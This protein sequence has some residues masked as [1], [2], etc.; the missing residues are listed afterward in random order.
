MQDVARA[1]IQFLDKHDQEDPSHSHQAMVLAQTVED[2]NSAECFKQAYNTLGLDKCETFVA[3]TNVEILNRFDQGKI[4]TLVIV[5]RLL[6]GYD[7]NHVSVVGIVR[8]VAPSSKVLFSQFVGRAVR[9]AYPADPVTAM[10][11]SHQCFNQ[12]I[13]FDNFDTVTDFDNVDED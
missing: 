3:N 13:N 6:E 7:N 2:L 9:K 5:G 1:I 4:R 8:N 10:I 12:R 11:V